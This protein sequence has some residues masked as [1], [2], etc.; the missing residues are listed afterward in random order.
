M[1]VHA[2]SDIHVDYPEN[3][4]WLRSLSNSDFQDD[5]L[6]LAG[7]VSDDMDLLALSFENLL[8][9]FHSLCFIPGNHELWVR[10]SDYDCSLI[11]FSAIQELCRSL[12]V[13]Y[14]C[15]RN[16]DLSLVPLYSWYDY[17]FAAPDRHLRRAWRDY[18]A[19]AWPEKF[20]GSGDINRHFLKLNEAV[21][22]ES[23]TTVIS[24]SHFLPRIDLMPER[25]PYHKR[26]VYPVLGSTALGRQVE[27]LQP[28]IHVYGHSHVNQ[29]KQ[30]GGI[31]YVNNAFGYPSETWIASKCLR[32]IFPLMEAT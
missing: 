11:K 29:S 8:R 15:H 16:G 14:E 12:G 9:K 30:I 32:C 2:L 4:V 28:Q 26:N 23:N 7:D 6:I 21:L 1:R 25:I 20:T 31:K 17:S 27:K 13:I 5:I 3:L 19:C 18:R 22:E 10:D 24:Y